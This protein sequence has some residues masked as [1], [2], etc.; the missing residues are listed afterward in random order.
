MLQSTRLAKRW[1]KFETH[2][3][4]KVILECSARRT[5]QIFHGPCLADK[6]RMFTTRLFCRKLNNRF[7]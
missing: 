5:N 6:G 2:R 3:S 7:T 1:Q 4:S